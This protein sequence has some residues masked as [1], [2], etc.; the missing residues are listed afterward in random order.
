M[1]P[2]SVSF[3]DWWR[4]WQLRYHWATGGKWLNGD[5]F[6]EASWKNIAR[7]HRKL[8]NKWS[9][10]DVRY[11]TKSWYYSIACTRSSHS[12]RGDLK[13]LN[14]IIP[15]FKDIP[16]L[17]QPACRACMRSRFH[18][19]DQRG[20]VTAAYQWQQRQLV[21]MQIACDQFRPSVR[22]RARAVLS[23]SPSAV[24]YKAISVRQQVFVETY[25]R[26]ETL[27]IISKWGLSRTHESSTGN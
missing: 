13:Q 8:F 17:L 7:L 23:Q 6:P 12:P 18:C 19:I 21:D 27:R 1:R 26:P 9:S 22:A 5:R 16:V 14:L 11:L 2:Y 25:E 24:A 15:F 20:P 4:D 3:V 10:A